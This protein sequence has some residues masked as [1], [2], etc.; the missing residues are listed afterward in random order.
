VLG[1]NPV[2][3]V[4]PKLEDLPEALL[5][6][7]QAVSGTLQE[8]GR[9]S[10]VVGGAV[11]DLST[12]RSP[13]DLDIATDATPDE[14]ELAFP[15]T[16]PLGKR[17]GTV[18]VK[19]GGLGVEVTTLRA[20]RGYTDS[21]HPA[22]VT[23]GT[24]VEDD[25][26]RRDFTC[27]AMY[28]DART[29]E[30]LDPVR[31]LAD[32]GSGSLVAVGEPRLRF[33]EDGLRIIRLARFAASLGLKP[34]PDTLSGAISSLESLRGVSGE[35]MLMEFERGFASGGGKV[36]LGYLSDIGV[37]SYLFPD[38]DPT[39]SQACVSIGAKHTGPLGLLSGL[40]LFLDP[41]PI[42]AR[43]QARK[44]RSEAALSGLSLF[45]PSRELKRQFIG[46]WEL[47]SL[48]EDHSDGDVGTG[49]VRLWMRDPSWAVSCELAIASRATAGKETG[50]LSAWADERSGLSESELFPTPWIQAP[51][52]SESGIPQG[53]RWGE[54][55]DEA[56]LLQLGGELPDIEAARE[57]LRGLASG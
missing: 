36:M 55:L 52:L 48:L 57:W 46:A 56:L 54:I 11:R 33:E 3:V 6:A 42:G 29:G 49:Q 1:S 15:S 38:S 2:E 9:R 26:L 12:G 18:L 5:K 19:V 53:P 21:R 47:C 32:L 10:W 4:P 24:S 40:L 34:S 43:G 35:R 45:R 7:A 22:A 20:E 16:V 31:G 44:L 39:A 14:V 27:N 23:F 25:A 28:L 41:D 37:P 8:A 13:S 51:Q 30:F 17:F 50:A